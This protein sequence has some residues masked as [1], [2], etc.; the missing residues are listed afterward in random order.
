M[1]FIKAYTYIRAWN[2]FIRFMGQ[3]TGSKGIGIDYQ[4]K[5]L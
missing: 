1:E 3:R 2:G 4:A 5:A